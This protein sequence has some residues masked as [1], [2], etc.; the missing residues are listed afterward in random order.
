MK[1]F[2]AIAGALLAAVSTFPYLVDIVRRKTKPNIVTWL[3]WTI[4]T[5][6]SGSAALAAG[7]PKTALLLYGN[8]L[9]TGAVVVLGLKY[10]IAKF[11]PFDIACQI[12]AILGLVFWLIF[13]SPTIGI[14]VPLIIDFV[15][16]LPTLRHAYLMPQEET[17]QTFLVGVFAPALTILSLTEYNIA[18]LL[19][20]LY[21]FLANAAIV[22]V[23]V[24]RRK[25]LGLP[26]NRAETQS[27]H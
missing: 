20:P 26:L 1:E 12:G 9:C 18:S 25:Q 10:G 19:F 5:A 16:M 3:T 22:I 6:I 2:F 27:T 8:S 21:L 14:I 4:L 24:T 23:V 11:S 7:E 17:W 13:N 15:G